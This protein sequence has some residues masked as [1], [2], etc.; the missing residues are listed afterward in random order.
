MNSLQIVQ[1]K[2]ASSTCDP[3]DSRHFKKQY[4]IALEFFSLFCFNFT[5]ISE[6]Q[7]KRSIYLFFMFYLA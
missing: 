5:P 2:S 3:Y 4:N 6:L 1:N 7:V